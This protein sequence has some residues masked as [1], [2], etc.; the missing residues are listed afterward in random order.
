[1]LACWER[2]GGDSFFTLTLSAPVVERELD[3]WAVA[4]RKLADYGIET[5]T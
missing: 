2:G 3:P 1:V 4:E 5:L